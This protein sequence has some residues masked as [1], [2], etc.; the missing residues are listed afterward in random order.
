M[1]VIRRLVGP[2]HQPRPRILREGPQLTP[3]PLQLIRRTSDPERAPV[4]DVS[5]DQR[6]TDIRVPQQLLLHRPDVIPGFEQA[7]A[8][9][10]LG[11]IRLSA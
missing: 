7:P 6:R 10:V 11:I 4:Q 2:H 9:R 5:V 3:A 1:T 8:E